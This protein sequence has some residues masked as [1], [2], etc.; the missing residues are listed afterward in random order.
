[1]KHRK[2]I[3]I[4]IALLA[5]C[6][7]LMLAPKLLAKGRQH[8]ELAA[9]QAVLDIARAQAKFKAGPGAGCFTNLEGLSKAG[10]I[11]QV[12]YK[13]PQKGYTFMVGFDCRQYYVFAVPEQTQGTFRTGDWWYSLHGSETGSGVLREKRTRQLSEHRPGNPSYK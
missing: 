9:K 2:V 6:A 3:L 12:D 5:L 4:L 8:N 10:L 1:M 7:G 11:P 13:L